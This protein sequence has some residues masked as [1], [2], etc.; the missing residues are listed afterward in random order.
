MLAA[1]SRRGG[2]RASGIV[3]ARLCWME[4]YGVIG[5][6]DFNVKPGQVPL[7]VYC[8]VAVLFNNWYIS[9]GAVVIV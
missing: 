6:E 4:L 3:D 2:V 9:D 1:S 7:F 5:S 8:L